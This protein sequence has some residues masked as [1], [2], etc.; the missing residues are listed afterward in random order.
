MVV[1]ACKGRFDGN[2]CA[3]D[4]PDNGMMTARRLSAHGFAKFLKL[5]RGP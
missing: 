5:R 2:G 3:R 4:P 1:V